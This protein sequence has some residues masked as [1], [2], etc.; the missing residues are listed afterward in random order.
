MHSLCL[1]EFKYLGELPTDALLLMRAAFCVLVVTHKD[2]A[3]VTRTFH[4]L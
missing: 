1:H 4:M 2:L 3:P